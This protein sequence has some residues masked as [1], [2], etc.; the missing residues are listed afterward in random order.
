MSAFRRVMLERQTTGTLADW[1]TSEPSLS[2][3]QRVIRR[4]VRAG[5]TPEVSRRSGKDMRSASYDRVLAELALPGTVD[6]AGRIT[7]PSPAEHTP[8]VT[9]TGPATTQP[10]PFANGA[11]L[12]VPGAHVVSTRQLGAVA[13]ALAHTVA[14][15]GIVCVYGDTGHGKTVAVDQALRCR[16]GG[17]RPIEHRLQSN[18]RCPNCAPRCSPRSACRPPT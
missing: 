16:P 2:T 11:R 5:R 1:D 4:D 10:S 14:A 3:L 13:E 9:E 17:S 6:E 8:A 12:H 7:L 15:R 18:P